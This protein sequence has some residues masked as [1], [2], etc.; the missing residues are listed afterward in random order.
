VIGVE[1]MGENVQLALTA[2]I[3]LKSQLPKRG[4]KRRDV[5]CCR[6]MDFVQF[7]EATFKFVFVSASR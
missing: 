4:K 7:G 5:R 6:R 3:P 1:A 2:S